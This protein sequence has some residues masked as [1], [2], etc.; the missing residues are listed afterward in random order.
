MLVASTREQKRGARSMAIDVWVHMKLYLHV[1]GAE[2]EETILKHTAIFGEPLARPAY[3]WVEERGCRINVRARAC[4]VVIRGMV[5]NLWTTV[6]FV[7]RALVV[8][9]MCDDF[10]AIAD[11]SPVVRDIRILPVFSIAGQKE[12]DEHTCC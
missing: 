12:V 8:S 3:C 2:A 4:M 5:L 9:R 7:F 11:V 6:H 1:S 10:W